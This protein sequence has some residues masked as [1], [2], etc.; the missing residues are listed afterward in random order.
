[1]CECGKNKMLVQM[2]REEL[3]DDIRQIIR[4]EMQT[5]SEPDMTFL[6]DKETARRIK[7]SVATVAKWKKSGKL[8][9]AIY[10]GNYR[11]CRV[12]DVEEYWGIKR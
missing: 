11:R 8:K 7:Q 6:K 12:C 9:S 4:E 10:A 2:T 1:M 3:L 5:K